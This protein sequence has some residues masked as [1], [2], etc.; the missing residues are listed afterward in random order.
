MNIEE[1]NV[2]CDPQ[3]KKVTAMCRRAIQVCQPE[4][5][6]KFSLIISI[7]Q[8]PSSSHFE[9]YIFYNYLHANIHTHINSSTELRVAS[10]HRVAAVRCLLPEETTIRFDSIH[11]I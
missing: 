11:E 5:C 6:A 10:I 3:Y 8:A 1:R 4:S 2:W 9:R 7:C